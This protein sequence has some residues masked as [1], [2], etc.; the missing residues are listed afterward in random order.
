MRHLAHGLGRRIGAN[1]QIVLVTSTHPDADGEP[2]TAEHV[3]RG[4]RLGQ[5]HR[6]MQLRHNHRGDQRN[7][8][9][10]RRQ[11]AEQG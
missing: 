1:G 10:P 4:Q 2:S 3:A 6:I 9:G 5:Q 8:I 11:G 7:A